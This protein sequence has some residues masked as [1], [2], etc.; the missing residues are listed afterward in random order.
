MK[1]KER[2]IWIS[3]LCV[4]TAFQALPIRAGQEDSQKYQHILQNIIFYAKNLYVDPV[5]DRAML[6]GAIR[7]ALAATGD[8]FTR[9]LDRDEYAEFLKA[10]EGTRVGIGVEVAYRGDFPVVIAPIQGGPAEKAGINAGDRIIA[11]DRKA[12][13]KLPFAD[14]LKMIGG[15][16]GSVVELE[17][18]R[19]GLTG[20]LKFQVTRGVFRLEYCSGSVL[21]GGKIGYV[22]LSQFF[23]EDTGSVEKFKNFLVDFERRNVK[24]IIVDLRNNPGGHLD[25]AVKL[26]GFFL[27]PEQVVVQARGRT[28]DLSQIYRSAKDSQLVSDSTPVIVLINQGSAS[29]SEIFAGALQDHRR[30][31][32]L[33]TRS[34]GKASVQQIIGNL[35]DDTAALITY[36]RYYTPLNRSIHGVGLTPDIAVGDLHSTVDENYFLYKMQETA[37]LEAFKKD[38]PAYN[39]SLLQIFQSETQKRGWNVSPAISLFL[40]KKEY[41]LIRSGEI[42]LEID[43]QLSRAVAEINSA[44]TGH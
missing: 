8:P 37:F 33:G 22:R 4:S 43:A 36:Q 6:T 14:L 21:D 20:S 7:G 30:A 38:H 13:E 32:L 3:L 31:R 40:L 10:Q 41:G 17:I 25:M 16:I 28:A 29:A 11:I 2:L 9:F 5:E 27:K 39:P 23:G 26:S 35:P 15:E 42:D 1:N 12:T 18:M 44:G 34:F 19:E 24:G